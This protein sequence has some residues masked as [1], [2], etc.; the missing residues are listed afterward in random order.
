[1]ANARFL[2][3]KYIPDLRRMEPRNIGVIVWAD[4]R[5]VARFLGE[6]GSPDSPIFPPRYLKVR[7]VDS[8]RQW[9]YYWRNMI[10]RTIVTSREGKVVNISSPEFIDSL[11]SKS[12]DQFLLVEGGHLLDD[13]ADMDINS[14]VSDLFETLVNESSTV[15]D[16]VEKREAKLLKDVCHQ[17]LADS[18]LKARDDFWDSFDWLCPVANASQHFRFDYALHGP[19]PKA[20]YQRVLLSRQPSINNA[21]FMFDC[22]NRAKIVPPEKCTA[23]VRVS[24]EQ[25]ND[26][27]TRA[28]IQ[29]LRAYGNVINAFDIDRAIHELRQ[30]AV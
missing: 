2:I 4:G 28:S 20:I 10:T 30:T 19:K 14:I 22:M 8:Y 5:V 15:E 23:I 12:R 21:A 3:A 18:G 29:V 26:S 11:K 6:N 13:I 1:M 16:R 25:Q 27:D 9:L 7:S 17:L 24:R